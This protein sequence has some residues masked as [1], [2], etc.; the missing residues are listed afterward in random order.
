[1]FFRSKTKIRIVFKWA[2]ICI[3]LFNF[4]SDYIAYQKIHSSVVDAYEVTLRLQKLERA[5]EQLIRSP[6]QEE[7][8]SKVLG[9]IANVRGLIKSGMQHDLLNK[10]ASLMQSSPATATATAT[11]IMSEML[12]VEAQLLQERLH[13]DLILNRELEQS[14]LWA[15]AVDGLLIA[16]LLAFFFVELRTRRKVL[17]N[18]ASS[19]N[20][21]RDANIALQEKSLKRQMVVKTT[22]HDLKNP[23]G[24]IHGFA[25]L[26]SD[27]GI[28]LASVQ[29]FSSTI[30][31]ISQSSL[32][33]VDTLLSTQDQALYELEPVD[34]ASILEEICMQTEIQAKLKGQT[35]VREFSVPKATVLGNRMKLEE[36][37]SNVISNA[38]KYSPQSGS[39]WIRSQS[40]KGNF[41]V[42]V[43]DQGPGFT[44]NDK[45]KAFQYAQVLSAKPTGNESSTGYGL[46]MAKQI[47]EF[48]KGRIE[49]ND[50]KSGRGAC[51]VFEMPM[52]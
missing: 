46:F 38:I 34:L 47:T 4:G 32:E 41:R 48:H 51:V 44:E 45:I 21:L 49:I 43:E 16:L 14:L 1:M 39:I 25:E 15:L 12:A 24:S 6:K 5:V 42:E 17:E 9:E 3:V 11:N 29:D 13:A 35:F 50:S 36:L 27:E 30:R 37:F 19:L 2:A 22:V 20:S 28:T 10:I 33:L 18:L 31:R 8:L 40:T 23:L 7:A 52:Q 26:I